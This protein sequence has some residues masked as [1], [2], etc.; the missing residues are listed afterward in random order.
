MTTVTTITSKGS[1]LTFSELDANFNNLNNNKIERTVTVND[2]Q[3][4]LKITQSGT[5]Q[6]F[7]VEDQTSDTTPFVIDANGNVVIGNNS[8]LTNTISPKLSIFGGGMIHYGYGQDPAQYVFTRNRSN[9]VGSSSPVNSTDTLGSLLFTGSDGINDNTSAMLMAKVDGPVSNG[10]VPGSII[11]YTAGSDGLGL[12][13]RMRI[14]SNSLTTISGNTRLYANNSTAALTVVQDGTG[15]VLRVNDIAGDSTPFVIDANGFVS[16]SVGAKLGN[17]LFLDDSANGGIEINNF[18]S[19]DRAAY[20]DLHSTP[21]SD[22]NARIIRNAGV[23][24]SLDIV[25]NGLGVINLSGSNG[26]YVY[27]NT[28]NGVNLFGNI[29]LNGNTTVNGTLT[30]TGPVLAPGALVQ[31]VGKTISTQ[32]S[33]TIPASAVDVQVGTG[34][35]FILT[36][37]PKRSGSY[38]KITVRMFAETQNAWE[39]IYNIHRDGIRVNAA[40]NLNYHGLSMSCLTYGGGNDNASTP[41]ILNIQTLDK[42]G[43]TAGTPISYKLVISASLAQA[44]TLYVNRCIIAPAPNMETG[45]SEIILEEIAQ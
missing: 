15:A 29:S 38:I 8:A 5:G 17:T 44:A 23:D 39:V 16:N 34:S 14:D 3:P 41:D 33:Q 20:I 11:M 28:S 36:I 35:D 24:G 7:V 32:S 10:K 13:E 25:Q 27:G 19:I 12:S 18:I 9:I 45:I 2:S 37:T 6:A 4:G 43:T 1:A 30:S 22:Y 31:V 21:G 42:T 26:V 40:N